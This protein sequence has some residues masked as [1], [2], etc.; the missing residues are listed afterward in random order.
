MLNV[1]LYN[2]QN[3]ITTK[4]SFDELIKQFSREEVERCLENKK[5]LPNKL[6]VSEEPFDLKTK[7]KIVSE[8]HIQGERWVIVEGS[9]NEY[10]I[11]NY[12][13]FRRLII[14]N[15]G[16][17]KHRYLLPTERNRPNGKIL[18][19]K[20]YFKGV[21]AEYSVARLVAHHFMGEIS[22]KHSVAHRNGDEFDCRVDNLY[23]RRR[24][25]KNDTES[26][27]TDRFGV[28]VCKVS[29]KTNEVIQTYPSARIAAKNTGISYQ[30]IL[31]WCN[32]PGGKRR[33]HV[34]YT[35]TFK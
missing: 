23:F 22:A 28:E 9:H 19:V 11:S 10:E 5:M 27:N 20:V 8:H 29:L 17:W 30:T 15:N 33:I 18:N 7:R 2:P 13:R 6:F 4:C 34:P 16:K 21:Y 31:N 26:H 1:F 32:N 35:F 12:G 25:Y 3:N 24:N 14:Y